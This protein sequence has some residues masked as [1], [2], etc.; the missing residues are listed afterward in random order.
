MHYLEALDKLKQGSKLYLECQSNPSI[1]NQDLR[2]ELKH[3]G[4]K[5]YATIITCSDSRVPVQ[6]IFSASMGELFIIRNAGNV[7]GDFEIGSAEYASEHLGV[8][9]IVVLGH[10][11]CGAVDAT[12]RNEGHGYIK[13]ITEKVSEA[14][15]DEK[16]Q[17]KAEVIN[18]RYSVKCL[19]KSEVL[20]KLE[21]QD[22]LKI[23][24]AMYDIES[25]E[26]IFDDID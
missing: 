15:G 2:E 7:I 19:K 21:N 25:G 10:T 22:K 20:N 8:E 12:V 24:S 11:H 26:V 9:L 6:H 13:S 23:I 17:R 4:Q 3:R 5:P 18:A 14:I 16:D 1:F